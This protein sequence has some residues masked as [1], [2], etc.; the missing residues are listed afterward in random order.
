MGFK[1][2]V[3]KIMAKKTEN[4]I[5]G[6]YNNSIQSQ[7]KIFNYLSSVLWKTKY[8]KKQKINKNISIAD[9]QKKIPISDYESLSP[10]I[11]D[12]AGGEKDVLWKGAPKYFA[13]TS[14]TTSGIKYI[15]LS[16]EMLKTQIRATKEALLLYAQKN[17]KYDLINGKM[18]FLQGSP[19]LEKH[20][21]IPCGRLSGIVANYVPSF[22]QKNRLPRYKTNS[23][24]DWSEKINKIIIE[25]EKQ[26]LRIIGGIPPWVIMYFEKMSQKN[27]KKIKETF[28]NLGLYVHGG[29]NFEPYKS[30]FVNLV[31]RG[32]DFLE[33]YPASEGFI[34]YQ[35]GPLKHGL[36][37]LTNHG[38]F[39]EFI[40][41]EDFINNRKNKRVWLNGVKLGVE[42]VIILNTC[43]GLWGYNI[44]DTIRFVSINPYRIVITGRVQYF[45]SAFGE[46][47]IINDV[48]KSLS[49][50]LEKHGGEIIGFTVCPETN[51]LKGL[52]GHDWFV[53]FGEKPKDFDGFVKYLD[54]C[55]RKQNI[56]Y[57][58]LV[59]NKIIRPLKILKLKRGAFNK[60]MKSVGRLGGQNKCP[61]LSNDRKIG[62]YLNQFIL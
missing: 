60:Y 16:E 20:G 10:F 13:K 28:P 3:V 53:E 15:P 24:K 21:K 48:E 51:P 44:G 2:F 57:G 23:I 29:V 33:L 49:L 61:Q 32:V 4:K 39:Y 30:A 31:G 36:L 54:L 9:F 47:V 5:S 7:K 27:N 25:T 41:R 22:L 42:Y 34:A 18:M 46:H 19:V 26:D 58:D 37:L 56:Y 35:D 6:L 62:D 38:I 55:L 14:G 11:K 17:K 50:A 45:I 40:E 12:I 52:P 8:G 59:G 1:K 43:A